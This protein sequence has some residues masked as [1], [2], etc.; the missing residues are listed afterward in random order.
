METRCLRSLDFSAA[1]FS[2]RPR[3]FFS[4]RASATSSTTGASVL[5]QRFLRP[6]L[7]RIHFT[8]TRICPLAFSLTV[9]T[10]VTPRRTALPGRQLNDTRQFRTERSFLLH[11]LNSIPMICTDDL[12][13]YQ[14]NTW[15]VSTTSVR[16]RFTLIFELD[17]RRWWLN[18][19]ARVPVSLDPTI[20]NRSRLST[21]HR[22]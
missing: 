1:R 5:A 13:T 2:F 22:G 18:T 14:E 19:S 4:R 15:L 9:Q 7:R 21:N 17:R 10:I 11:G 16:A 8:I 12:K 6:Y 20:G 3:G